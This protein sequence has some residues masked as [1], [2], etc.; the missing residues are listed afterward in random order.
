MIWS[1]YEIQGDPWLMRA[2]NT[3]NGK[4][5]NCT[6]RHYDTVLC[7]QKMCITPTI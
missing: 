1:A 7:T 4:T 6:G 3:K 2:V 5:D